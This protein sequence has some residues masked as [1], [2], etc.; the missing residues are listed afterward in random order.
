MMNIGKL[1]LYIRVLIGMFFGL[2][3]G[4]VV[5]KLGASEFAEDW[6]APWGVI[7]MRL[8]KLIAVPL[9]FLSL[10]K[11]VSNLGD[12]RSLSTMGL[13][14]VG[15]YILTTCAAITFGLIVASVVR[16]GAVISQEAATSLRD[17]AEQ[18]G[19][20]MSASS[21]D[22]APLDAIVNIFPENMFGAMA[23]NNSMLQVI[24]VAILIGIA[25]IMVDKRSSEPM[26]NLVSSI[27]AIVIKMVDIVMMYAPFGVFALICMAVVDSAGDLSL[28]SALGLYFVTVA[29]TLF[30]LIVGFYPLLIRLFSKLSPFEF[31][32][33]MFPVQLVGFSTSSSAA[34]LP[35]TM[36]TATKRLGISERTASFV[37]PVGMTINMDGTS[38]YQVIA[39]IFIAQIFGVELSFMT[40]LGLITVITISSIGTPG[41]PGGSI[42]VL[43]MVLASAGIP[44]EGL[45]LIMAVD[46]PLDM[47]RTVANVTGDVTV[48]AIVDRG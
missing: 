13:K 46:R 12:I 10:I 2:L 16:P 30:V 36:E 7:F 5:T 11:G 25:A 3:A 45:A 26:L 1:P 48:A 19:M 22:A 40:L 35:L 20:N 37:L 29:G 4:F 9:V 8:L 31:L 38:C 43:T 6:I 21:V 28:L 34:T 44:I 24:A 15:I 23:N 32:K 14:V 42:V 39:S 47:L 41:I 18:S 27:E 33:T 17:A